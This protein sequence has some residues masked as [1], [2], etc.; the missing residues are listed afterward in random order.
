VETVSLTP[1]M[2][3]LVPRFPRLVR[4]PSPGFIPSDLRIRAPEQGWVMD[5]SCVA[6]CSILLLSLCIVS[7][8]F[9][10]LRY[11]HSKVSRASHD[12]QNF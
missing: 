8:L 11:D 12:E 6:I 9:R 4:I 2:I 3:E 10:G 7:H 5:I 1:H